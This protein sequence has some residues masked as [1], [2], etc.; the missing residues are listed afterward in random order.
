MA[1]RRLPTLVCP[2]CRNHGTSAVLVRD[3]IWKSLYEPGVGYFAK[4]GIIHSPHVPLPFTSLWV[5][6][7]PSLSALALV[8]QV[9]CVDVTG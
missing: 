9:P 6:P 2:L 5:C 8:R 4:G 3:Y 1:L 7:S